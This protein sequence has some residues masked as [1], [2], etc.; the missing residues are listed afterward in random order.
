MNWFNKYLT[1]QREKERLKKKESI[2]TSVVHTV[3]ENNFS[4]SEQAEIVNRILL[5]VFD[6][7][8]EG[9]QMHI[10]EARAYQEGIEKLNL[11]NHSI[12]PSK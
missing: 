2:I 3:T 10:Q 9:R 5:G 12:V 7:T 11:N 4:P 1:R 8:K 6:K